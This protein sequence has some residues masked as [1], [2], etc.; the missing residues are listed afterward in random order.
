MQKSR[1]QIIWTSVVSLFLIAVTAHRMVKIIQKQKNKQLL[2]ESVS[3]KIIWNIK[4]P[5]DEFIGDLSQVGTY[6]VYALR[7]EE[8]QGE[9]AIQV[10]QI[11]NGVVRKQGA[12][13]GGIHPLPDPL[14]VG[15]SYLGKKEF[16]IEHEGNQ[17]VV[18]QYNIATGARGLIA[19]LPEHCT[20]FK[21]V[22]HLPQN[23]FALEALCFFPNNKEQSF[24]R[25]MVVELETRRLTYVSGILPK[26][27]RFIAFK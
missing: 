22:Q 23:F 15:R 14:I 19:R 5:L 21:T 12:F 13:G 4:L 3:S 27:M 18:A 24:K 7:D 26:N 9:W 6:L 25:V 8:V 2:A 20:E 11:D 16:R 10:R 17:N 1:R